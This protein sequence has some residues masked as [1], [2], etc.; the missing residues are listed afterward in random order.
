MSRSQFEDLRVYQQAEILAD[1]V[2]NTVRWWELFARE[3]IG[4]QLVRAVDSVGAN[5]AEGCGRGTYK[6][7]Q[8]F[9]RTARGSLY[10]TK[11]WLRRAYK[12][13]LLTSAEIEQLKM[14]LDTLP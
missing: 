7:N 2:W 3:T 1:T 10:E 13:E 4:R 5:I 12:R 14:L 11:H 6:D 8:R 9:V